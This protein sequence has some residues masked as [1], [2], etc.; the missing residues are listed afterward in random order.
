MTVPQVVRQIVPDFRNELLGVVGVE[1]ENFTEAFE[2]N[3][4]EV[5]VRQ[6]F[7]AGV[8]LYHLLLGEEVRANQVPPTWEVEKWVMLVRGPSSAG[9]QLKYTKVTGASTNSIFARFSSMDSEAQSHG[10]E[11]LVEQVTV[12]R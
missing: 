10:Y 8:G 7:H 6:G 11:V 12:Q 2:A 4:L 1:A 3:V 9:C 5:A